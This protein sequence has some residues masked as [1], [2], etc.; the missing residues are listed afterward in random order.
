MK[1]A[2][3]D[4]D[5]IQTDAICQA[6][7]SAGHTCQSFD[8]GIDL[9]EYLR[10][11]GA[12]ILVM[13]WQNHDARILDVHAWIRENLS[14]KFPTLLIASVGGEEHIGASLAAGVNDY[15]IKPIRRNELIARVHV[16]LNLAYPNQHQAA[17]IVFGVYVFETSASRITMNG[18]EIRLTQKE[19]DLALLFFINVDQPLSRA[20]IHDAIWAGDD[21]VASR[22]LDTHVSRVRNKLKLQDAN[23]FRLSPIYSYGYVLEKIIA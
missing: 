2:V 15:V 20:H 14:P 1:I 4:N 11:E 3:L 7:I 21:D 13:D 18:V 16:Q 5:P 23:G 22:T 8:N 9:V 10:D 12:D 17:S 19:F 6:L